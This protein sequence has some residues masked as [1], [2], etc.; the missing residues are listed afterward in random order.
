M[1]IRSGTC[2]YLRGAII[3]YGSGRHPLRRGWQPRCCCNIAIHRRIPYYGAYL[4]VKIGFESSGN[5]VKK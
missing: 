3:P 1:R 4:L 5:D 2:R